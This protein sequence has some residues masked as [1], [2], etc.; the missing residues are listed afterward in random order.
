M[1]K[2]V[3]VV[4]VV[5]GEARRERGVRE[6][7]ARARAAPWRRENLALSLSAWAR[8]REIREEP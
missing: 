6:S 4:V 7:V 5:E 1:V 2:T 8:G 3:V